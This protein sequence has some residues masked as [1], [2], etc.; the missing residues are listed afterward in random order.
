MRR[1]TVSGA[2]AN[3]Y[4]VS[5]QIGRGGMATVW[6]AHDT[7]LE[8]D[9]ALKR[10]R[11]SLMDDAESAERFRREAE[12]VAR[13]THPGLVRLLDRGEDEEGPFLVMELVDGEDLKARIRREGALDPHEAARI[14]AE[15]ARALDHAH[16]HGIVHRDIKSQNVLLSGDGHAKLTDFGIARLM[17]THA[18]A[19][20]TRT[21][22]LVGSSDYLAP[23]QAEGR[24]VDGRTDVYSLGIVLWECL[25]GRLPFPGESF[26]AIAMRHVTDPLPDPRD[27][28]PGIPAHLAACALRAGAKNPAHR[29]ADANRF[30][31]ALEEPD[32][33]DTASFDAPG[34][35]DP[36]RSDTGRGVPRRRARRRRSVAVLGGVVAA[37][38]VGAGGI[39]AVQA[40]QDDGTDPPPQPAAQPLQITDVQTYD[41]QGDG[42]EQPQLVPNAT[43]DNDR[44]AWTTE[45]YQATPD[46]GGY[47]KDGVG[48]VLT[49]PEGDRPTELDITS[50]TPGA[51]FE[52]RNG[53][54]QS[55]TPLAQG[56]FTGGTQR[57]QLAGGA[58]STILLWI[59]RLSDN[60]APDG[61]YYAAVEEVSV[62]GVPNRGT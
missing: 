58:N 3:R 10:L 37:A 12:T 45:Y 61:R 33:G 56:T 13:L 31:H 21:G 55:G 19:G 51:T 30:A 62:R 22:M 8:R 54:T 26:L 35:E 59:T 49:V 50:S 1:P 29:F 16:R 48:L 20:L 53:P 52:V 23:E 60:P 4:A 15:V 44:T 11:P 32:S 25:T 14:C 38:V 5:A 28:V 42:S 6:R 34:D 43:D 40:F 27:V 24:P 17:E 57:V 46:F 36:S 47:P 41:P 2:V 7:V 39:L 9:V 18:D